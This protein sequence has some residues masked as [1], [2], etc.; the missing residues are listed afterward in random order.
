[1]GMVH[2]LRRALGNPPVSGID[3][4]SWAFAAVALPT[5]L[6]CLVDDHV[7]GVAFSP[8]IPFISVAA[9]CLGWR[10]AAFVTVVSA[11]V[12]D[13]LFIDPRFVPMAGP[14][15]LFGMLIFLASA[16]LIIILVEVAR[17]MIDSRPLPAPAGAARTGIIFSLEKGEAFAS[18]CGSG[19]P[20]RLG[21]ESEVAE[22]MQD[23]LAQLELGRRL[24]A[25]CS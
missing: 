10:H 18:W 14:T 25:N 3:A 12:A 19:R 5:I 23:F 1:M 13:M 15:D 22:M 16:A 6:R 4:W 24:N 20:L 17:L 8:Y 9:V 21:P 11:A 2:L 7:T